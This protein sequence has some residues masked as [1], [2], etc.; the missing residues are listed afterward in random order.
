VVE[1]VDG[2]IG[3]MALA[4]LGFAVGF[5]VAALIGAPWWLVALPLA[6]ILPLGPVLMARARAKE[7]ERSG[8]R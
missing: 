8:M 2:A 7:D 1:G 4:V 6:V 5:G 3:V